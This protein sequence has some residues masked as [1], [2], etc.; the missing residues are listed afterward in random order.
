MAT[1]SLIAD[2]GATNARFALVHDAAGTFEDVRVL[3][4]DEHAS[5]AAAIDAYLRGLSEPGPLRAAALAVAGPVGGEYV[6]FTN[7]PWSFSLA[8]LRRQ[9]A[10]ERLIVVNDFV[11]LAAAIPY[12]EPRHRGAVGQGE[13]VAAAPIGALGP[14][15]G[16]CMSAIAW[17]GDRWLPIAG[18]GGHVTMAPATARESAVLDR[19]RGRFDHVSAERVLSGPGLVHLYET[20]AEIDGV[21]A[22][23]YTPA[24][25][26]DPQTRQADSQCREAVEMFCAMLGTIAGNLAL[27]LGAR[28]GIYLAGGIVPRLGAAFAASAFRQ[29]FEAKGRM[30]ALLADIPTYVV[31]HPLPAL[32]GLA[33]AL[34]AAD[35]VRLIPGT[36][37]AESR[38]ER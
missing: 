15:F 18:E 36:N 29:R 5:L 17:L 26:A 14:G 10:L 35:R 30:R 6:A 37:C 23:S 38:Q 20:L 2:V 4:C 19:M 12:L 28:G 13:A 33:Q 24:Q 21:L 1:K 32:L 8:E 11:A 22:A 25:I 16:L 34:S 27:T 3:A 31:T 9:L 7:H